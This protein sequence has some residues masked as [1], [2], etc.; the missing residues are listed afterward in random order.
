MA[1]VA[2]S[3]TQEESGVVK[4][5]FTNQFVL[6]QTQLVALNAKKEMVQVDGPM[7]QLANP[8]L[9]LNVRTLAIHLQLF[10]NH[11]LVLKPTNA[12]KMELINQNVRNGQKKLMAGLTTQNAA[13]TLQGARTTSFI[14]KETNAHATNT[15]LS[16][17]PQVIPKVFLSSR[18]HKIVPLRLMITVA[19]SQN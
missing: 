5:E 16:A 6:H 10:L 19:W 15:G 18:I 2:T 11:L 7:N 17:L 1:A 13:P 3:F 4:K 9:V 8:L 14:P 12:I